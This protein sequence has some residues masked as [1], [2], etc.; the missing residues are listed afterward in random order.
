MLQLVSLPVLAVF[1]FHSSVQPPAQHTVQPLRS[2]QTAL[3]PQGSP[4]FQSLLLLLPAEAQND[5][6]LQYP[7]QGQQLLPGHQGQLQ[8][9]LLAGH[10]GQLLPELL[11]GEQGQS[12]CLI[13]YLEQFLNDRTDT[14]YSFVF[15]GDICTACSCF[16]RVDFMQYE[17]F[18]D[19]VYRFICKGV[20]LTSG[21][22]ATACSVVILCLTI[23]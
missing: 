2:P 12:Q 14:A 20:S 7:L 23:R 21:H 5:N 10:E 18:T 3:P 16:L 11:Q 6:M 1:H 17:S 15:K 4:T 19:T 9:R 8:Q 13:A 22:H